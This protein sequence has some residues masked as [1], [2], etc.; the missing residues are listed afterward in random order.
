MDIPHQCGERGCDQCKRENQCI[1][2]EDEIDQLDIVDIDVVS[3]DLQDDKCQRQ[4]QDMRIE[5][6]EYR[7]IRYGTEREVH[8]GQHFQ[9]GVDGFRAFDARAEEKCPY[10][11]AD[12]HPIEERHFHAA[13]FNRFTLSQRTEDEPVDEDADDRC[14]HFP[15]N[16]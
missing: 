9:P 12:R 10:D 15:H 11:E 6:G 8:L 4:Q 7:N 2:A 1:R 16:A 5:F 3:G 13:H 14:E